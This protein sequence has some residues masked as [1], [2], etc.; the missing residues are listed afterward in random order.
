MKLQYLFVMLSIMSYEVVSGQDVVAI[1]SKTKGLSAGVHLGFVSYTNDNLHLE[2]EG[3]TGYGAQ[4]QYGF[5]HQI[6]AA[7]A[8][9]HYSISTKSL[10]NGST[11]YNIDSPYPYT[12]IELIGKYIFGSTNSKLRPNIALGLNFTRSKET[13]Y[14]PNFNF[15]SNETYSGYGICGGGGLRYFLNTQMSI[16]FTLMVSSGN[17]TTNL[18]NGQ[19]VDFEHWFLT[20]KG[21][22]GF[23]YH[24]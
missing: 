23:M 3:G 9:Q 8:F 24:F 21:L 18:V 12:E 1:Q 19:E 15:V 5:N 20:Y 11:A 14:N 4:L 6:A 22:F 13:Y 2:T 16:D 10:D 7:F 17:F